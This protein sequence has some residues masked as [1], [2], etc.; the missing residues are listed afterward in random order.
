MWA[1]VLGFPTFILHMTLLDYE[2]FLHRAQLS[3]S[4]S[5]SLAEIIPHHRTSLIPLHIAILDDGSEYRL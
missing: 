5:E 4:V 1:I 3:F 2:H